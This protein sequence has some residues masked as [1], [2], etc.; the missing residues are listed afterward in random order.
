M[1]VTG[2]QKGFGS[3]LITRL[4]VFTHPWGDLSF[5]KVSIGIKAGV[6]RSMLLKLML[7]A[8]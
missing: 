7:V 3:P 1:K 2:D 6:F 5:L 4:F 8:R